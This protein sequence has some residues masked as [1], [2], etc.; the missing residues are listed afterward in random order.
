MTSNQ[1]PLE[2]F[3][4]MAEQTMQQARGAVDNYFG[5]LQKTIS[6]YPSG[7]TEFGEKIKNYA[8]KNIA[9]TH[10]FV[11]RL[12]QTKDIQEMVR[13]QSEF[14]QAQFKEFGE[15]TKNLGEA[16]TKAAAEGVKTPFKMP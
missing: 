10:E 6:S 9:A 13:L 2:D 14:M 16:Y 15:Q 3:S 12:T 11:K 1:K 7:G 4:A 8:E 5:F